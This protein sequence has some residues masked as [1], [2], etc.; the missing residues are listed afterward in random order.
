MSKSIYVVIAIALFFLARYFYFAPNYVY[1]ENLP[2]IEVELVD[3]GQL[4]S[5]SLQGNLVL[6]DFWGSWCGPCRKESPDL[7]KLYKDYHLRQFTGA[8]NFEIFSIAI[9]TD[10]RRWKTAIQK[11]G[12]IWPWHYS[13]LSRF[14]DALAK[15]FGVRQ[16]PTKFLIDENGM[17]ISVNPT[18]EEIRE[19]LDERLLN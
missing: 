14:D 17:I 1:G 15:E 6:I 8:S 19:I 3:G 7:V 10:E 2:P 13:S 11:D 9:E 4:D 5:K 16:I 12:L 18:F